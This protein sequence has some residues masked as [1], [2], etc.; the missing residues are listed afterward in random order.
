LTAI[1]SIPPKSYTRSFLPPQGLFA[2]NSYIL[3]GALKNLLRYLCS[4]TS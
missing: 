2:N 4:Y 1:I 3:A